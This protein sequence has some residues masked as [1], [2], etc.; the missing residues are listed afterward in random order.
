MHYLE[1]HVAR[2]VY[3]ISPVNGSHAPFAEKSVYAIVIYL[4]SNQFSHV[5]SLGRIE[6]NR[7]TTSNYCSFF[8]PFERYPW[9]VSLA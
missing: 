3:V 2:Q 7:I 6:E 5:L 8:N 4:L 1:G 9:A